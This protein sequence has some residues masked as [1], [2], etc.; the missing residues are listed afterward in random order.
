[1]LISILFSLGG[2]RRVWGGG[3]LLTAHFF[4]GRVSFRVFVSPFPVYGFRVRLEYASFGAANVFSPP[5]IVLFLPVV[6]W[7]C[8]CWMVVYI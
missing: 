6:C 7:F 4:F 2:M 3:A 5:S 1:M 8:R